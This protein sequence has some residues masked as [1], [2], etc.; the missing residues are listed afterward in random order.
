M[1]TFTSPIGNIAA[2]EQIV[3]LTDNFKNNKAAAAAALQ[4]QTLRETLPADTVFGYVMV[5]K[6]Y[7]TNQEIINMMRYNDSKDTQYTHFAVWYEV[8]FVF[9]D[10]HAR[11]IMCWGLEKNVLDALNGIQE[12]LEG[13]YQ[14]KAQ[15]QKKVLAPEEEKTHKKVLTLAEEK[16]QR[17]SDRA[18]FFS[19]RDFIENKHL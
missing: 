9:L 7:L 17:D 12:L 6:N 8:D 14:K 16:A 11:Q 10:L 2:Y 4:Q 15:A 19:D 13:A 18:D 3:A 1:F 5:D